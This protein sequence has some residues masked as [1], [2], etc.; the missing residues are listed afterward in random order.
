MEI[1]E[2]RSAHGA[3]SVIGSGGDRAA[4][5]VPQRLTENGHQRRCGLATDRPGLPHR[6]VDRAVGGE[7]DHQLLLDALLHR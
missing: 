4:P 6:L 3:G 5:G 7:P 2:G 1:G